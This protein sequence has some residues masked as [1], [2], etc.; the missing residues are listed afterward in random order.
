MHLV[1]EIFEVLPSGS[2]LRIATVSSL[3]MALLKL[4]RVAKH[5]TNECFIADAMTRQVV[6][7]MNVPPAK[8]RATKQIFQITYEEL[9]GTQRAELLRSRGYHVI[10]VVGNEKAKILLS[11][12]E[13]CDLFIVGHGAPEETRIEMVDWLKAKFPNVKILALNP[14]EQQVAH[15]DYNVTHNGPEKWLPIVTQELADGAMA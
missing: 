4:Q 9:V 2:Q 3:E 7:R 13:S 11:S 8:W 15:A 10:S 5:T 1:Y 12:T 6:A 14:P